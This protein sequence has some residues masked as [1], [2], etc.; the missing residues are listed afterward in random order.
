MPKSRYRSEPAAPPPLVCLGRVGG[1]LVLLDQLGHGVDQVECLSSFLFV[2]NLDAKD[3][4]E[5]EI[6]DR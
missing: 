2:N 3:D 6:I 4:T 5:I 1:Q